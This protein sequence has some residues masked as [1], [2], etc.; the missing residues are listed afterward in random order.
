MIWLLSDPK[1]NSWFRERREKER[2][3]QEQNKQVV[4]KDTRHK[5]G[6]EDTGQ[7]RVEQNMTNVPPLDLSR[8][9][10]EYF[11][12]SQ[13]WFWESMTCPEWSQWVYEYIE[14]LST[15]KLSETSMATTRFRLPMAWNGWSVMGCRLYVE[16]EPPRAERNWCISLSLG[17]CLNYLFL[18]TVSKAQ[19][20]CDSI[21]LD[22]PH[23][24]SPLVKE[25]SSPHKIARS[26]GNPSCLAPSSPTQR[27]AWKICHIHKPW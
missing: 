11:W 18:L 19:T 3:T 17:M 27:T 9:I 16:W 7:Y 13:W 6:Q 15:L 20:H 1:S 25:V 8:V 21:P 12:G 24:F 2:K 26:E 4:H 22:P 14:H 10:S 5:K 23:V